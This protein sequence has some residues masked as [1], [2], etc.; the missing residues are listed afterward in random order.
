MQIVLNEHT[1]QLEKHHIILN[2]KDQSYSA[3]HGGYHPVEIAL[4]KLPDGQFLI[5]YITD[6]SYENHEDTELEKE[7]DFDFDNSVAFTRYSGW[8]EINSPGIDE[9]Y[10]LWESNFLCYLEIG[11]FDRVDVEGL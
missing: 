2:F 1:S 10:Q 6:F 9:L 3:D 7:L 4:S 5:Q 8:Q 11:A